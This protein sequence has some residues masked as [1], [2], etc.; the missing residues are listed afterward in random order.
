MLTIYNKGV[1]III[2]SERERGQDMTRKELAKEIA[3]YEAKKHNSGIEGAKKIYKGLLLGSGVC[4]PS[5][6]EELE[7]WYNRIK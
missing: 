7:N 6:K 4:K 1:K 5:S 2:E 3:L